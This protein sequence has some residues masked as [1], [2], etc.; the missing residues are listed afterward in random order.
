MGGGLSDLEQEGSL[1]E[2]FGDLERG[3]L[4]VKGGRCLVTENL[5]LVDLEPPHCT[6]V[7]RNHPIPLGDL[8]PAQPT[9]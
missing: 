1:G 2:S 6:L 8:E 9:G 5:R 3:L 4:L 7:D